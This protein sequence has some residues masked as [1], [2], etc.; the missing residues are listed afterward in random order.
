VLLFL[1]VPLSHRQL[2]FFYRQLGQQLAV[3]LTLAQALR[4]PSAA[5]GADTARLAARAEAGDSVGD[6]LKSAGDWLPGADRPLLLAGAEA[7]AL[8]ALLS[9]LADR[10]AEL[11][12]TGRKILLA[13]LY[14]VGVFHLA[15]FVLSFVRMLDFERG[16]SGGVPEYLAGLA[17]IL[18]PAWA[19]AGLLWAGWRRESRFLGWVLDWLPAVGGYRRERALADFSFALGLLLGAG[20]PIAAAWRAAGGASRSARLGR[21]AGGVVARIE[22]RGAPGEV[23]AGTG[24]FPADY[25]ARYRTGE[26]TG[27]LDVA[28]LALAGEHEERA[29]GR[30]AAAALFYPG[31]LFAAVVGMVGYVAL[32]FVLNY[33]RT[34]NGLMEG[35]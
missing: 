22:A 6:L 16:L 13:S 34:L 24:A 4:A 29:R 23:L 28:L 35:L 30:L 19:G 18:V 17:W 26:V 27:S 20:A 21:A 3:G 32:G 5:P 15:A 7:G 8:P 1:P 2:E 9:R 11:A 10:H 33:V 12:A 31:L 14:P 25:V